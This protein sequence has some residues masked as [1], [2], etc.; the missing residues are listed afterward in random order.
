MKQTLESLLAEMNVKQ[1]MADASLERLEVKIEAKA[2]VNLRETKAEI[3]TSKERMEIKIED[4][5]EKFEVLPKLTTFLVTAM[6][7]IRVCG[8]LSPL[9]YTPSCSCD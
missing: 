1:E 6:F 8:A 4:N 9:R 2:E 7:R 3:R 5:N